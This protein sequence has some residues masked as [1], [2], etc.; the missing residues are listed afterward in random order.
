MKGARDIRVRGSN[1]MEFKPGRNVWRVERAERASLLIDGA[2]YFAAA[3]SAM[4]KARHS[5]LIAGWDIHSQTRL[6]GP[7]AKA[8]DGYPETFAEFLVALVEKRPQLDIRLLLWD[9]S[10]LYAAE[11]DPFPTM[12]LRWNTPHNIRF[13]LDDCVPI[14]SSQHQK[15]VVVDDAIAFSGGLDLTI[16]R[17][18]TSSHRPN[19]PLRVDPN[20]DAYEPFHDVQ[21][22]VEGEAASGIADL[23]RARWQ[24]AAFESVP[25][26]QGGNDPW[27][28]GVEADLHDVDIGIARTLPRYDGEEQAQEV[29]QLFYD[30]IDAAERSIYIENQFLTAP[31]IARR[32]AKRLTDNP[33]LEVLIVSPE[34][35]HSWLEAQSMRAGRARFACIVKQAAAER[36]WLAHP[37]VTEDGQTASIM[38][39]AKV[40]IVD[41]AFLRVGSANL[42]NRS[43]G[44]DTECDLAVIAANDVQRKTI[45]R[46]RNRLISNHCGASEDQVAAVLA[47]CGGS[48]IA[49][50]RSLARDGHSLQQ[51]VDPAPGSPEMFNLIA[52]VADPEKP[53]GAEQFVSDMFG[54]YVPARNISTILK[55]I[56]AGVVI[57]AL[58][59]VWQ[60]VPLA[61]PDA[62]K[63]ELASLAGNPFAPAII[64]GVF[65]ALGSLMFPITV[66]I[67]A[68]AAAFGPW[69][70]FAY[71]LIGALA[72]ALATY[73]IG[74]RIGK[75]TLRDL[76]GPKLNRIRHRVAKRGVFAIAAIRMV[77][78]APFM[79]INLA[80]GASAIPLFDYMAGT[81]LGMLPGLIMISAVG[82]QFAHI[83][84]S[85]TPSD[86]AILAAAVIAWI[87]LSIGVQALVSRYWSAGR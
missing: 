56:G 66:L 19:D 82:N 34:T 17:W 53:I 3:R 39:H 11:R 62:V 61:K 30:S 59:L 63:A 40:M 14:G 65:V 57:L 42:N 50:A 81:F 83:L 9:F 44:T 38:V 54:G 10:L 29:E 32:L 78:I 43:M 33:E 69:F 41:D 23:F 27:P 36:V 24:C 86:I 31:G 76:L 15:L 25:K 47:K 7:S 5:I 13:C 74:A 18:D 77:P 87:A 85:S 1:D 79:V 64:V 26:A 20:G 35:H 84:T 58:A 12:S 46:L 75:N 68:T 72:S 67:A 2:N 8:D 22:L 70:G 45:A 60:F 55:V 6:V 4:I 49:V 71:A 48:L 73:W 28:E 16:R 21:M 52:G 80:A 37:Q 51:I